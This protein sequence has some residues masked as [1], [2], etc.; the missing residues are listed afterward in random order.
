VSGD[1]GIYDNV[2]FGEEGNMQ[3]VDIVNI[4][5]SFDLSDYLPL[6]ENTTYQWRI[7]TVGS[8]T[9][10]GDTWSFTTLTFAPPDPAT[11]GE[12]KM[13]KRLVACAENRFWYE[14]I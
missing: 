9:I 13:I 2:Y 4:D 11:V 7:D 14:A 5:Q 12:F 3:Q 10:T 6:S 8:V 1:N